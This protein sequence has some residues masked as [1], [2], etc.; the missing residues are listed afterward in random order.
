MV[1]QMFQVLKKISVL[2][3]LIAAPSGWV[4]AAGGALGPGGGAASSS[5][6][7]QNPPLVVQGADPFLMIDLSVELT[8][9]AEAFTDGANGTACPG[10]AAWNG[11]GTLGMCFSNTEEYIGYFDPNKCY[12]YVSL[13]PA[14]NQ[15]VTGTTAWK[16]DAKGPYPSNGLANSNLAPPRFVPSRKATNHV[17]GQTGEFSGNFLN[18]STMTAL[19]QFRGAMTGGARIVD[20]AGA[21]ASTIL[22]R[23]Y[24][25]D[26]WAF[27]QKVISSTT[28]SP[29]YAHT[30]T[31]NFQTN[32][33][34]VTPWG[35]ESSN[36]TVA[37]MVRN[38]IGGPSGHRV[39]FYLY[40]SNGA[41]TSGP[42]AYS[43]FVEVCKKSTSPAIDPETNCVPY[44]DTNGNTWYKPEG[45]LQKN[46]VK[47]RYALTSYTAESGNTRNGGV[48]RANA[49]YVGVTRPTMSGGI[50][51]NPVKEI[52]SD[53]TYRFNPDAYNATTNP[54]GITLGNGVVN[55]GILNYINQFGLAAGKY[56]YNDPVAEL[57]YE[58]LRYIQGL[59]PTSSFYSGVSDTDKD[60]YPIVT[61]WT[62][63]YK[64]GGVTLSCQKAFALY[65]GDQFAWADN[66]LP[67]GVTNFSGG[68]D[69]SCPVA[70]SGD[71]AP[72]FN[73]RS[74]TNKVGVMQGMGASLSTT[75]RGRGNG[76]AIAGLAYWANVNDVRNGTSNTIPGV[77]RVKTYMVDTQEYNANPPAGQ[78][79]NLW[80]AAKFGG[81]DDVPADPNNPL[82]GDKIPQGTEWD[83]DGNGGNGL[84]D[85]YTLASQPAKMVAGLTQ[86][87]NNVNQNSSSA[88]AAAV[89]ANNSYSVGT[90]YQALYEPRLTNSGV[91][92]T[93]TGLVRAFF[94]DELG[95]VREDTDGNA[96]L[97][98]ADNV[99]KYHLDTNGITVAQ[100]L[101][102][103]GVQ[104]ADNISIRN[105]KPIWNASTR[106]SNIS[107][108]AIPVQRGYSTDAATGRYIFTWVDANNN[109][110]VDSGEQKDFVPATFPGITSSNN[111][112]VFDPA[113]LLGLDTSN[114][115]N[116]AA[117]N[118]VNYIRGLDVAGMR[119]RTIDPG[120]GGG[121][122]TLRMGDIVNSAPIVVGAPKESYDTAF[123][124]ATY[125]TFKAQYANRAQV[126]YVGGNDGMLHAFNAGSFNPV[127]KA[128]TGAGNA[129]G[130]ELWAYVPYNLLPH[131]RW[132][133]DPQYQHMYY[134][135]GTPRVYDVN[136][137]AADA[138][139]PGGWGTILIAG[140]RLGGG[141]QT[142]N[143]ATDQV[144]ASDVGNRILR[145]AYVVMDITN[146]A[147][148]P[149]LLAEI[150]DSNMG[151]TLSQPVVIKNRLGVGNQWYLVMG[152]GPI[153]T[154]AT[155]WTIAHDKAVSYKAARIYL[156][157][158]NTL[159][160]D[161][162][163]AL[164]GESNS[165]VGDMA[166][167]DWD[168]NNQDEVVYFGTVGN[169]DPSNP[170]GNLW[171][172]VMPTNFAAA[173]TF[174]QVLNSV[175][176]PF[177]AAPLPAFDKYHRP[178][179]Y[180]G[181]GRFYT[182]SDVLSAKQ[183]TY[184]GIKENNLNT[185]T[186][187][188]SLTNTT[189]ILVTPTGIVAN[190]SG[191]T[192]I[193]VNGQSVASFS[194]LVGVIDQTSGWYFDLGVNQSPNP[195]LRSRD[196]DRTVI[197]GNSLLFV[198]Y[199][200]SN[201]TCSPS[202]SS[203]L[204]AP[205]LLTGTASPFA[206]LGTSTTTVGAEAVSALGISL[207]GG[208]AFMSGLY[209]PAGTPGSP[210]GACMK[211]G[212]PGTWAVITTSTGEIKME[213]VTDENKTASHGRMSW[214][215][216]PLPQ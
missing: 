209:S 178:W 187:K 19:D 214:R 54:G 49:R 76:F 206:A 41:L 199:T 192:P 56:K 141:E 38:D 103:T 138:D 213:C 93:W 151:H 55:S 46:A 4:F 166:S 180:A 61:T 50:E 140:F 53:G 48:L 68:Y 149:K 22:A 173:P 44:T 183:M 203:D 202:G 98:N 2:V 60:G 126:V 67:G 156:Y 16:Q 210:S 100:L 124:D 119:N 25:Y 197:N 110:V 37:V 20:T 62:D 190:S 177:S 116:T 18:W 30:G 63:P 78:N 200:A 167:Q 170:T 142:I 8:Q 21:S 43:V 123:S 1:T 161:Y 137:F 117:T 105:L 153:G 208:Q 97:T 81:F 79:N 162:N 191:T 83:A 181:A 198:Q 165:F 88:S 186:N 11:Q 10:R 91:A 84:P 172:M 71:T 196:V 152:S 74:E 157:N 32:I 69:T 118:L 109:G 90:V 125:A 29:T 13:S 145:P 201:D 135:D 64:P 75:D 52:N 58:G 171:R 189:G 36:T 121:S 158:L 207:G 139:H 73:A 72:G 9:Q 94:L 115:G 92:V 27:V 159:Q 112:T 101:T 132:L 59:G 82:S 85:T 120:D 174:S 40:K 51:D 99:V 106:L 14:A 102:P 193:T 216:I 66:C 168:T 133:A 80:L 188:S 87:F 146:P 57:Y 31:T 95:Q 185:T 127:A 144:S 104:V 150:S 205:N 70:V 39:N 26:D 89:V 164:G 96:Q 155:T 5:L 134:V 33:K 7:T 122:R 17:C 6:Y 143:A 204:L 111:D 129:L 113:R 24:R 77:Q 194:D 3:F 130:S 147:Q 182:S 28:T 148:P 15:Y 154:D 215:E 212:K 45:L 163:N 108:L 128:Y 176:Q 107:N 12:T 184:Y 211:N 169:T 47:M 42:L 160:M 23:A 114:G 136:T 195:N 65:V 86:V 131:L 35:N 34:D 179:I 175:S